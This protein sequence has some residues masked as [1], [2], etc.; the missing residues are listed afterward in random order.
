MTKAERAARVAAAQ[1]GVVY[2]PPPPPRTLPCLYEGAILEFCPTCSTSKG[3]LRHVRDCDVHEKAT[4]AF[5]SDRVKSCDRCDDYRRFSPPTRL[6]LL[7]HVYPRRGSRWRER[8]T[9]LRDRLGLFNGRKLVAVA[10]DVTTDSVKEVRDLLPGCDVF[11]FPNEP[12]LREVASFVPLFDRVSDLTGP[13]DATL[14]AHAKGVT[15]PPGATC[16][17]WAEV[18]ED[19]M[20]GHWPAVEKVL[21]S[22]PVAGC[23]KKVGRG[24]AE[25]E[26]RSEWHYSGSFCWY[27]NAELFARDWKRIDRFWAGIEP[28]PSLHFTTDEAGCIFYTA[29]V[30]RM[31]LYAPNTWATIEPEYAKWLA[32]NPAPAATSVT[33]RT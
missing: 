29:P 4:R 7:Y 13:Q 2:V 9:R 15:R 24:W 5:V 25:S 21:A 14:Y 6:H 31:N 23:F 26:S 16:H 33:P 28:Y 19:V 27:R 1:A 17:R 18:L 32:S 11:S 3:E 8:V 12:S 10:E 30:P 22:H 20:M